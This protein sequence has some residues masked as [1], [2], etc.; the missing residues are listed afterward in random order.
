MK[1]HEQKLDATVVGRGVILV[2]KD[3]PEGVGLAMG[4][5]YIQLAVCLLSL[6]P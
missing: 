5:S 2:S 1:E 3:T 6:D 4:Q